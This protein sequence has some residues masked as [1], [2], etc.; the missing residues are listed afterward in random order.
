MLTQ[1]FDA[2]HQEN[3]GAVQ[4]QFPQLSWLLGQAEGITEQELVAGHQ[5]VPATNPVHL[6]QES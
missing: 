5:V 6:P 3:P 2:E 4:T 1:V